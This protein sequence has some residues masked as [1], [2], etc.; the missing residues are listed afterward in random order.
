MTHSFD[1]GFDPRTDR[2]KRVWRLDLVISPIDDFT[3]RVITGGVI[4]EIPR[5]RARA[6]RS[7]SGHLTF[8]RLFPADRHL[9][10]INPRAAG[11]FAPD[12]V[13]IL[14]PQNDRETRIVR[15]IRRP[16]AVE[17]GASMV[18]RGSVVKQDNGE[19]VEGQ[20]VQGRIAGISEPFRTLTNGRGNFALRLRPP[21]PILGADPIRVPVTAQVTLS[22]P[23][24]TV[25]DRLLDAVEDMRTLTLTAQ[26]QIP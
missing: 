18:V 22:F 4:A 6:R 10:H 23:D 14:M 13:E 12:P 20:P 8:E 5:Q 9:V 19:P 2:E 1:I 25:P 16:D 26:V 24:T 17:D 15:L 3:G 21:S 11:Y 7:S